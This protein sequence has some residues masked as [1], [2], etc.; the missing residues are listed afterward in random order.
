V[1]SG[2]GEEIWQG[3]DTNPPMI[4]LNNICIH[5]LFKLNVLFV[6]WIKGLGPSPIP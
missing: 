1:T 5:V 4:V 2:P 3:W 6:G